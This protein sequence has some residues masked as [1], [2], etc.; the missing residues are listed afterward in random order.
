MT[1]IIEHKLIEADFYEESYKN[2]PFYHGFT[3]EEYKKNLNSRMVYMEKNKLPLLAINFKDELLGY[4]FISSNKVADVYLKSHDS[5]MVQ[6]LKKSNLEHIL[7]EKNDLIDVLYLMTIYSDGVLL[8]GFKIINLHM[9]KNILGDND[10]YDIDFKKFSYLD[11]DKYFDLDNFK[12]TTVRDYMQEDPIISESEAVEK[13]EKYVL[14][15]FEMDNQKMYGVY[16]NN[17]VIGVLWLYQK[18]PEKIFIAYVEIFEEFRGQG[19]GK[20]VMH[21]MFSFIKKLG[22]KSIQLHVFGHNRKAIKLYE[23][24]GFKKTMVRYRYTR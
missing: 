12:K 4:I 19:F 7:K 3:P 14:P 15:V 20:K 2:A 22:Y 9:E 11:K 10:C 6:K 1:R 8:N 17:K 13:F 18:T 21:G 16:W 24:T 23:K 5:P